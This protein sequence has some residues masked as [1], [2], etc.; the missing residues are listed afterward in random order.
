MAVKICKNTPVLC[1][2]E[3]W[4]FLK[5]KIN[6]ICYI[7]DL[8]QIVCD[9]HDL[10]LKHSRLQVFAANNIIYHKDYVITTLRVFKI[11]L[12]QQ[13]FV[14]LTEKLFQNLF[15]HETRFRSRFG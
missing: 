8:Y 2:L 1:F 3:Y 4:H 10:Y 5:L 7:V 13:K 12:I 11:N 14:G 15:A 6:I 9:K